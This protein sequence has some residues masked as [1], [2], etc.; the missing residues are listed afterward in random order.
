[1]SA[2]HMLLWNRSIQNL[3]GL[4]ALLWTP[5]NSKNAV[6]ADKFYLLQGFI[7]TADLSNFL[8]SVFD[9]T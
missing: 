6:M 7:S 2:C 3:P 9:E 8:A 5:D 4:V 1:M